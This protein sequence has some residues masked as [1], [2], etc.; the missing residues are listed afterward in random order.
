MKVSELAKRVDELRTEMDG[1]FAVVDKKFEELRR[2][3]KAE[4]ETTR[5]HFEV[6][7]EKMLSERNLS[8]DRSMAT[9]QQLAGLTASNAADHVRLEHRL[10]DHE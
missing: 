2:E 5:R 4:G 8:L 10:D 3:I 6:V 9:A 1:K 7:A